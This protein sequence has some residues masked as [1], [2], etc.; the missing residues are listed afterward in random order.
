MCQKKN[1][2]RPA[3]KVDPESGTWRYRLFDERTAIF[4]AKEPSRRWSLDAATSVGTSPV[5]TPLIRKD[6]KDHRLAPILP[7]LKADEHE[8]IENFFYGREIKV[9]RSTARSI[10]TS[11]NGNCH[12]FHNLAIPVRRHSFDTGSQNYHRQRLQ[13]HRARRHANIPLRSKCDA[14]H[15]ENERKKWYEDE[16]VRL[17]KRRHKEER[18]RRR[19]QPSNTT[20]RRRWVQP[21]DMDQQSM[22]SIEEEGTYSHR[23]SS[24]RR[25]SA[26]D[27]D[28]VYSSRR[29]QLP[30]LEQHSTSFDASNRSISGGSYYYNSSYYTDSSY[31]DRKV[32]WFVT[33]LVK[34]INKLM[35]FLGQIVA[36]SVN[37][38][39]CCAPCDIARTSIR[40]RRRKRRFGT[41]Q[42]VQLET[43]SVE[44]APGVQQD[45][46]MR[47]EECDKHLFE[48]ASTR[49]RHTANLMLPDEK[50]YK[51]YLSSARLQKMLEAFTVWLLNKIGSYIMRRAYDEEY[52]PVTLASRWKKRTM[53]YQVA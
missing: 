39:C 33:T 14:E 52:E 8:R 25:W 41:W 2:E 29:R 22:F 16:L 30:F 23:S 36:A 37:I 6:S 1:D 35:S 49:Q 13:P 24:R 11:R 31:Q 47:C 17:A 5:E 44:Q 7:F 38:I 12:V 3:M 43:D 40:R 48:Q 10:F 50:L 21:S 28:W 20:D 51:K 46:C 26:D 18:R 32:N 53:Y 15:V 45:R 19:V 34:L 9:K 27:T 42:D 4:T